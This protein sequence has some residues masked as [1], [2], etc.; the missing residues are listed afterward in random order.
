[1]KDIT[2]VAEVAMVTFCIKHF[3]YGERSLTMDYFDDLE[4][5]FFKKY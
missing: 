2:F 5:G 4:S 1:M 3:I